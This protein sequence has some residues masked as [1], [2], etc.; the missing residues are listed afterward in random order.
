MGASVGTVHMARPPTLPVLSVANPELMDE[1][2]PNN[3]KSPNQVSSGSGYNALWICST[4][5]HEWFTSVNG[6][7]GKR[8]SGCP[9][10]SGYSVHID[11]RNSL[12][13]EY[14]NIS[15]EF[16]LEKNSPLDPAKLVS[17]SHKRVWWKCN[18]CEHEWKR[19]IAQRTR[20]NSQCPA[21]IGKEIHIDGRNSLSA[22]YP[23]IAA[24]FHPDR[25]PSL[26]A[27]QVLPGS[28]KRVWWKCKRCSHEWNTSVSNRAGKRKRKCPF[29]DGQSVHSDGHNSLLKTH[30]EIAQELHE[31]LNGSVGPEQLMR[32][33][34]K[35]RWWVCKTISN[36]P[37]GH[38]WQTHPYVRTN[39]IGCPVC[40]NRTIHIDGRNSMAATHPGLANELHPTKNGK[41]TAENTIAG[42]ASKLWWKCTTLS[43]TP[44]GHEWQTT[45][46]SRALSGA[47]CP[48]CANQAIH[49]DG[50]NSM[51]ITHPALVAEFHPNLNGDLSPKQITARTGE[52][53][54]WVCTSI[55]ETP[56]GYV[57]KA[58]RVIYTEKG[59]VI[60]SCPVCSNKKLHPDGRNSMA[61]L[62]PD[63]S[64]EFHPTKNKTTNPSNILPGA[65]KRVHWV[66]TTVSDSPCGH[67]WSTHLFKR[68]TGVE[69]GCPACSKGDFDPSKPSQ[70]YVLKIMNESGDVILYKGGISNQFEKRFA[71]HLQRF[72]LEER[73][74]KWKLILDELI[75]FENGQKARDLETKLL[76][77]KEIRAPNIQNISSELFMENPL[78]FARQNGL[79]N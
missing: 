28:S 32:G 63:L 49:S 41:K 20:Q 25:N 46:N 29:C 23:D 76:G 22:V 42:T 78:Q 37:C 44:C 71:Q 56:C 59:E 77:M 75:E 15:K 64:K 6:R 52:K 24:D 55:S 51:A 43:E 12:E 7:T 40:A 48:A 2:H 39:G 73:S 9:A 14:P 5:S 31:E 16:D 47:G 69:T 27:S 61:V 50:R 19:K 33:S 4:C 79:I 57:W 35:K 1:W 38:I 60:T 70:Y 11:G 10:C 8:K 74:K 72:S 21:C 26:T 66:C 3:D 13:M 18:D 58:R 34:S 62:F 53:L 30:P 45:G 36:T 67:E 17:G 68:T 65:R 54:F